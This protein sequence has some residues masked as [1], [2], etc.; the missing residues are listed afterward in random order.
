MVKQVAKSVIGCN[1]INKSA[2]SGFNELR[3]AV[4]SHI[5]ND[6]IS[7]LLMRREINM[8]KV[9]NEVLFHLLTVLKINKKHT[10]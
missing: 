5:T 2:P 1:G 3:K 4:Q 7:R 6:D 9:N 8:N 10:G